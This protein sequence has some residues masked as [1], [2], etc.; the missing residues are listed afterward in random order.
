MSD[1]IRLADSIDRQARVFQA[2]IDVASELRE[3][4]S[5]EQATIEAKKAATAARAESAAAEAELKK[6]KDDAKKAKDKVDDILAAADA[7]GNAIIADYQL[8]AD[9][10]LTEA[11]IAAA[12]I[13]I[14]AAETGEARAAALR[15]ECLDLS[16]KRDALL[17]EA[18]GLRA[19][20]EGLTNEADDA[21]KRLA[22][23]QAQIDKLLGK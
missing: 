19:S 23:V 14:K 22:K 11:G 13:A 10:L 8:K 5:L 2:F 15:A 20:I 9:K 1:K 21:E 7:K 18:A 17:K 6:A 3:I 16:E 12:G 4:G